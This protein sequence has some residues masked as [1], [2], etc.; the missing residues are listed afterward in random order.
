M[1]FQ[2]DEPTRERVARSI[3][4]QVVSRLETAVT[5]WPEGYDQPLKRWTWKPDA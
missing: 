2:T 3:L 1:E 5:A 4:E